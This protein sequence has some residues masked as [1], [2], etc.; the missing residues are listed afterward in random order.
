MMILSN[1]IYFFIILLIFGCAHQGLPKGGPKDEIGPILMNINPNN[2]NN[3]SSNQ[4]IVIIF[5]E[6]IDPNSII[7]SINIK[8]KIDVIIKVRKN[9]IIIKPTNSWSDKETV[10]INLSRGITDLQSNKIDHDIQLIYN[11][12]S[13]THECLITGLLHNYRK[14]RF[15]NIL[16]PKSYILIIYILS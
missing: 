16:L 9:K 4:K 1:N 13:D 11:L 5:D 14:D 8:P 10:E 6:Y 3:L 2:M 15:Y 12:K 7:K